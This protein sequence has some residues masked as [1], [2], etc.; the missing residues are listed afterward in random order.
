MTGDRPAQLR[1]A[2][3]H[4]RVQTSE[5]DGTDVVQL[6]EPTAH[7]VHRVLRL[8]D[9]ET[10]TLTDGAGRWRTA[11]V[12]G[13]GSVEAT[14]Q[15]HTEPDP[16]PP[17]TIAAAMPK[18]DRL[19][20]LVQKVTELGA[21][22]VVLLHADRSIV[23]WDPERAERQAARLGRIADEACRQSRRVWWP[24]IEGPVAS[25]EALPGRLI[26]EPGGRDIGPGD[27]Y[28]AIGPEGGWTDRELALAGGSIGLGPTILRTET[29]AIA[30]TTLCVSVRHRSL[31]FDDT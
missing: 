14:S 10:V 22:R 16:D 19:D 13:R 1:A 3:A 7:H 6:D 18:G 9:G 31:E 11:V 17:I 20:V 30:A 12:A 24:T 27:C 21:D 25:T 26:A 5:L 8:R 15:V 4:L 29:A 28:V 2:A 23:R